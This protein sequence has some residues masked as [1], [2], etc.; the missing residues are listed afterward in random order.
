LSTQPNTLPSW[1]QE[2]NQRLAAHKNKKGAT[3]ATDTRETVQGGASSRAAEAAARVAA[4][5]AKAPS[6]SE[7]QAAETRV[8]VRAA[9]IAT[10][11]ALQAQAAAETALAEMHAAV[12]EQPSRGPA[13]VETF[14]APAR[15]QVQEPVPEPVRVAR[16]PVEEPSRLVAEPEPVQPPAATV[17]EPDLFFAPSLAEG[18]SFGIRWEPDMPVRPVERKSAPSRRQ[19]E[20]ELS[21]EDWWTPAEVRATLRNEPIEVEAQSTHANLIEFPREL[22]ATR[23]IRPR[24]AE[25]ACGAVD[26]AEGQLSIFE[27][28]PRSVSIEVAPQEAMQEY[29]A[30]EIS[31]AEWSGIELDAEVSEDKTPSRDAVR[32]AEGP[33]LAPVGSRMM[34]TVVDGALIAATFFAAA[35]VAM[36]HM[37]NPPVP[38]AAE[39]MGVVGIVLTGLVYYAFFFSLAICTPGMKYAGI[40][41]C[42]F[43]NE[44]PTRAQL[45][46]RL[47]AMVLSLL[48]V[49]LGLVW[50]V[51]DDDHLSWHDRI[52]QTYL[53]KV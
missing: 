14:A 2:V 53:R 33:F 41:L 22:V 24:L 8:A 49:G 45:R 1:K 35:F 9:E 30:S 38:K 21:A 19:E 36:S 46:R 34:A 26:E 52:S 7:M 10:Q 37:Q 4:R 29:S 44:S 11:V 27:V 5:Y 16:S 13:V 40:G 6:Y 15:K 18:Q 28:D 12:V 31:G 51:F 48:P 47:G 50:A 20:F 42:T 32:A 17:A 3:P 39:Q 25:V 43:D 23:K